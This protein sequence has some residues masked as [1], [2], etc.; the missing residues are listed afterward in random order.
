MRSLFVEF[1]SQ[2]EVAGLL[3]VVVALVAVLMIE[4]LTSLVEVV[5]Q[6]VAEVTRAGPRS[7]ASEGEAPL[8]LLG[9]SETPGRE[10]DL[11]HPTKTKR[12]SQA[13]EGGLVQ[14]MENTL[15]KRVED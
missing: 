15:R 4:N 6:E 11:T 9:E 12:G 2:L 7:R 14:T 8:M 13:N 3:V 10:R 5:G 1:L